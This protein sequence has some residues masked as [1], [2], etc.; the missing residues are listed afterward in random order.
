MQITQ[1]FIE[2]VV[3]AVKSCKAIMTGAFTVMQKGNASNLVTTAD[4]AVQAQLKALLKAILPSAGFLG[5]ESEE[6]EALGT[7]YWVVDPIDGT[8]DFARGMRLSAISVGLVENEEEIFGVVYCP[9]T[10]E[11]FHA[12][13][14]GG[15]YCNGAP[16]RV[17]DRDLRHALIFTAFSVYEKKF[18]KPCEDV[19]RALYPAI[20]DFRRLGTASLELCYLAAGRGELY[21]ELRLFPW[22]WSAAAVIVREAG[23]LIGTIDGADLRH[24]MPS[25]V[26]AANDA[27]NYAR[28]KREVERHIPVLPYTE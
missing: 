2:Q 5:E 25:L 18:A 23:G 13:K 4:T 24:D 21:F 22:D 8:S 20:D 11:V 16:I 17:S 6:K 3:E 15:A 28:L 19:L 12:I 7:R 14:G 27:E 1:S 9:Y 26:I 10:E